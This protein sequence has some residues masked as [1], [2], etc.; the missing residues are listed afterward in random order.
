MNQSIFGVIASLEYFTWLK[1]IEKPSFENFSHA[2]S[3]KALYIIDIIPFT[4]T[5]SKRRSNV[6]I[7]ALYTV[8]SVYAMC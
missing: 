5:Q 1:I 7:S 2:G 3:L 6:I 4:G 8:C